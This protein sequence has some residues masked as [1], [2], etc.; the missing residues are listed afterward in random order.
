MT[1]WITGVGKEAPGQSKN[2]CLE[3]EEESCAGKCSR[4]C[5]GFHSPSGGMS[6]TPGDSS[7][8]VL[9]KNE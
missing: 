3:G 8:Q 9:L 7:S 2:V 6:W 5:G 1:V 4:G